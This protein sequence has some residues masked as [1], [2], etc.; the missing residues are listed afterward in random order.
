MCCILQTISFI[1]YLNTVFNLIQ[2][3][4]LIYKS[5]IHIYITSCD[6]SIIKLMNT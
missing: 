6:M 4:Y 2:I 1:Y 3:I 5:Y